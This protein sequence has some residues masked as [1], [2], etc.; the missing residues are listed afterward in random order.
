MHNVLKKELLSTVM[1][2]GPSNASMLRNDQ[3]GAGK[4]I[5]FFFKFLVH[6]NFF[7]ITFI[8]FVENEK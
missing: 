8:L 7:T 2:W 4:G 6:S 5:T 3:C 1:D